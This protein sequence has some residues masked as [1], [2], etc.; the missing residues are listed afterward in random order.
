MA[1]SYGAPSIFIPEFI[2]IAHYFYDGSTLLTDNAVKI[3]PTPGPIDVDHYQWD[4]VSY[5]SL[6]I[7]VDYI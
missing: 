1:A 3:W 7:Y 4:Y 2:L 6:L 5:L